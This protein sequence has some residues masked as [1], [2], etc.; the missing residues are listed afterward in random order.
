MYV[1]VLVEIK[2]IDK[3]FTYHSNSCDVQMGMR[4]LVPFGNQTLEGFVMNVN[5]SF[6]GDYEVKDIIG[7][8]DEK[9]VLN[10]EMIELG[11]YMSKKYLCSKISCY[12]AML[13][14][15]LKAKKGT[16]IKEKNVV[17]LKLKQDFIPKNDSQ[18]RIKDLFNSDLV[19]KSEANKISV[20]AVK[21]LLKNDYIEEVIKEEYRLNIDY[22]ISN[23]LPDLTLEQQK[24]I[25]S[26]NFSKFT[27]YL[28]H[29]VTGSGKTEV[30]MRLISKVISQN[31]QVLVL[32]PEISLT[33]QFVN[34]FKKRFNK[35]ALLHSALSDGEKYDEW[36][37]IQRKEVNIV[38]GARSAVFAPLDN[39]GLIVIDEEHSQTYKQ[40]N[41]PMYN[42]IDIAINRSK[43]HNCPLI[44]G[45]ATPSIESYTRAKMGVYEFLEMKK[46]VNNNLPKVTLIDMKD[47]I[48]KGNNVFSKILID[49]INERLDKNE[50][51]ILL[52]NRRGYN[53]IVT[54][55]NCGLTHKCPNCDIPLTYHKKN[56]L[57]K[58]HYCNYTTNKLYKCPNCESTKFNDLGLGTEKLEDLVNK[59]FEKAK[60]IRMDIDTTSTKSAHE[61]ILN[62]FSNQEYNILIG[63]QMISKGLDFPKVTLVGVINGDA[64]LNIPDFRSGE[65]TYQLLNQVAGRAGRSDLL[66]EVIIQG[67]NIDHYSIIKASTHDYIGFYE[68]E[69]N[70]RKKLLYPP[71]YNI[72]LIKMQSKDENLLIKESDKIYAYLKE[73]TNEIILG[74]TTSMLPKINNIYYMNII[75]KYKKTNNI[76]KELNYLSNKYLSNNKIK[77]NIDFNPYHF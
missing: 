56:N 35:I 71:F 14:K 65:R 67:F 11:N 73:N 58:C 60:T 31:K 24:V 5:N 53:T 23:D 74:P 32:V 6:Q 54:C 20:S 8:I 49:K 45:T 18:K 22:N 61:K 28:L 57:M 21:T 76:I 43:K 66:G 26:I 68:E 55:Q 30:Y 10:E 64:T 9:P 3:T 16:N 4:V 69:M 72:V 1:E 50:Q 2:K 27:P 19:L 47:E 48:K 40:E 62:S 39:I 13:P 41:Y 34:T 36:R 17:Y 37:K 42:A 75:I 70:I 52:L 25:N 46:R 77:V 59:T 29:G 38:I 7:V 63:T 33:P 12:Q 51:V 15:A 44:L